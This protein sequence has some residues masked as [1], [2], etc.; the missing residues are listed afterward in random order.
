MLGQLRASIIY[1]SKLS[2]QKCLENAGISPAM[3]CSVTNFFA[4]V[5]V[6][7][8]PIVGSVKELQLQSG[9]WKSNRQITLLFKAAEIKM[10]HLTLTQNSS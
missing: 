3:S 1:V 6:Q 7:K 10:L 4:D 5:A 9:L 2:L 8:E